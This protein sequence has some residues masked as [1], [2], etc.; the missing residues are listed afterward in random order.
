MGSV[1]LTPF[2]VHQVF[3]I[4]SGSHIP[5]V[6]LVSSESSDLEKYSPVPVPLEATPPPPMME[7]LEDT[8]SASMMGVV[9]D[10]SSSTVTLGEDHL[11]SMVAPPSSLVTSFDWGRFTSYRLPSYVP[12]QITV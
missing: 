3:S 10:A 8:P 5:R 2:A 4:E 11:G 7:V 9:E 1:E 12:F 6:L